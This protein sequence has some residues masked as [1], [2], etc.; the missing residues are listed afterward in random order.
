MDL[1]KL[2]ECVSN[3][4]YINIYVENNKVFSK[5]LRRRT[6]NQPRRTLLKTIIDTEFEL[7]LRKA[8]IQLHSI[9]KKVIFNEQIDIYI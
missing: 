9:V 6:I 4:K 7:W 8:N 1:L 2:L 3:E 5:I